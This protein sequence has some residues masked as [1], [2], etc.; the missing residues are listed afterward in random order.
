[1]PDFPAK[2]DNKA[3]MRFYRRGL[4]RLSRISTLKT[5]VILPTN[6]KQRDY[7]MLCLETQKDYEIR[8][9]CKG[10]KLKK[11]LIATVQTA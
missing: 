11:Y 9:I 8:N 7:V 2:P 5:R 3:L 10:R 6:E 4:K 1:M